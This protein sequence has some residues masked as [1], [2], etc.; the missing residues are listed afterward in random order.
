MSSDFTKSEIATLLQGLSRSS[1]GNL[2][3]QDYEAVMAWASDARLNAS[4]LDLVL[5]GY[6]DPLIDEDGV[7]RFVATT[8]GLES[9][10][11]NELERM[12][13]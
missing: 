11:R 10:R 12:G 9:S 5:M 7:L 4:L 2:T 3:R 13:V 8:K 1:D 6:M